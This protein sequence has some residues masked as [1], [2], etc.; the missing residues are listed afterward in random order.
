MMPLLELQDLNQRV[1]CEVHLQYNSNGILRNTKLA[2][3]SKKNLSHHADQGT[4]RN[5][6]TTNRLSA[7]EVQSVGLVT[8]Q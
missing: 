3:F 6:V 8:G 7:A 4:Q 1:R 2:D 5:S